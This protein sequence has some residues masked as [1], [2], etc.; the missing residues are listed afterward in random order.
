MSCQ[1]SE[2]RAGTPTVLLHALGEQSGDWRDVAMALSPTSQ[3]FLPDLRGHGGSAWPGDYRL[4]AMRDDV[5]GLLDALGRTEV[6]LIGHSLGAAVAYLVAQHDPHRI[7]RLVLEEPPPPLPADPPRVAPPRPDKDVPFDWAVV[8]SVTEQRNS[9][10]AIWWTGLK[11]IT[12]PTLVIG[13]G[14][15]SH[16]PQDQ[17]EAMASQVPD[18]RFVSIP[19]GHEVHARD[20]PAF[21]DVVLPFLH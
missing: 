18:G 13:G 16:L 1:V 10:D 3:L 7:R 2:A 9:P 15:D 14:P 12:A 17:L 11:A 19:V 5:L 8:T 21:L 4:E 6:D 20:L